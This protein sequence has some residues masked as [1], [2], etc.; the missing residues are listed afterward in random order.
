MFQ[1][2]LTEI[3]R[4]EVLAKHNILQMDILERMLDVSAHSGI[5][6]VGH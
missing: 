3:R 6:C 5:V 1:E 4:Q 2:M